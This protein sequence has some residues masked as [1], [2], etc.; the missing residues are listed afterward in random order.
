M[1][2]AKLK[3]LSDLKAAEYN[4]R[5]ITPDALKGLGYSLEEFGDLSGIVFNKQT[6]N[7]VCGHQRVKALQEKYGNV[8][9]EDN[10][11]Q[12]NGH[13]FLIRIVNW[14]RDKEIAANIAANSPTI[15]GDFTEELQGL[16]DEVEQ[17]WPELFD[18]LQFENLKIDFDNDFQ[19]GITSEEGRKTLAE[20]FGVPPFSVL[21]ARQG[22]WQERKRA[23]IALGIRGELGRGENMLDMSATMVNITDESERAACSKQ[24]RESAKHNKTLGAIPPNESGDNGILSPPGKYATGK[25]ADART[26]GSGN[27]GDLNAKYDK[28]IK[29]K[30]PAV[31]GGNPLPL[32]RKK[33]LTWVAGD[34]KNENLDETSRKILSAGRKIQDKASNLNNAPQ[35]PEWATGTGTENMAVGTSI[36]DPVLCE[37][38]YRWFMPPGDGKVLDP[39]AGGSVRGIVAAKLGKQ[40]TGIDLSERQIE[41]NKIQAKDILKNNSPNWVVGD[42]LDVKKYAPNEY[43]FIFS[44]PPY[45]DLEVYSEDPRDLSYMEY[46][47]FLKTYREII[48]ASCSMLKENRFA[49][50][51]VGDIRDKKG[52]YRN[53]PA[54]TIT[55]FKDCGL[56]LYNEAVLVTAVGSLP[57]R[58]GKQFGSY[59]KL[60]KTH[61]NVLIFYKGDPQNIKAWSE[62]EFGEIEIEQEAVQ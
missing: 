8:P 23:W 33:R 30:I 41:A 35:K 61:Q 28:R 60:G 52:F 44:C 37:L 26:E 7:L 48:K 25:K 9:I 12:A 16:L 42:A 51:V 5:S 27:P 45:F 31:I 34:R 50:F 14:P 58:V 53:F 2:I 3:K 36:F 57:I 17:G 4:P 46:S 13:I 43:D 11:L 24:R 6:G 29:G 18:E 54:D 32:D 20:R 55:A 39:F 1:K 56:I 47:Q 49:C 19:S 59:R 22:Y 62:P 21:D 10:I 15:Q 40:Y 38:V